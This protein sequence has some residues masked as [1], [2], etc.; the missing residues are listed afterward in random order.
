MPCAHHYTYRREC[1]AYVCIDC[2]YHDQLIRCQCGWVLSDEDSRVALEEY[3]DI[4][5]E[6]P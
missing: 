2:G 1:V 5:N 4:L 3:D 6:E